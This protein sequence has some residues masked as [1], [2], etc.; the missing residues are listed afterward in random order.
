MKLEIHLISWNPKKLLVLNQNEYT[1]KNIY[2][3]KNKIDVG[4]YIGIILLP[5]VCCWESQ[6]L[7]YKYDGLEL[8]SRKY[9]YLICMPLQ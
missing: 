1:K 8:V 6:M 2:I 3:K 9:C 5:N 7:V 4:D